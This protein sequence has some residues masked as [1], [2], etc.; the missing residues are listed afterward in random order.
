[1]IM[2]TDDMILL[3]AK[4]GLF[5]ANCDG[6]YHNSEKRF[7]TDYIQAMKDKSVLSDHV[8][9]LL[10][11]TASHEYTFDETLSGTDKLIEGFNRFEQQ[12]L[13]KR[14]RDFIQKVIE[15]DNCIDKSEERYL[16]QWSDHFKTLLND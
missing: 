2:K 15:A 14:I 6:E 13:V 11:E 12:V 4:T 7:I 16:E 10:L 9:R 1:M 5:F 3:L 8:E